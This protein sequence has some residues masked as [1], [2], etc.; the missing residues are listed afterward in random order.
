MKLTNFELVSSVELAGLGHVW[1]LHNC[2]DFSGLELLPEEGAARMR[3]AVV[4]D[5]QLREQGFARNNP[6]RSCAI[7]FDGVSTVLVNRVRG[8]SHSSDARTLLLVRLVAP[9]DPALADRPGSGTR[10]PSQDESAHLLFEFMDGFDVE[11]AA[12]SATLESE[13]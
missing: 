8:G 5:A 13:A 9:L 3:W 7:R 6:A 1:D 4:Q 10:L 12:N 2:V 11:I